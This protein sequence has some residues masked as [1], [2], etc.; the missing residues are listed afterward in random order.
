M[1]HFISIHENSTKQINHILDVAFKLREQRSAGKA[2]EPILAGKTLGV[3]FGKPSLRTRVSFEQAMNE[4]GGHA[5]ILGRNEVGIGE[6]ES[7]HDVIKVLNGMIHGLAAR[8]FEHKVLTQLA[9][10]A[11]IPIINALSDY[12][13][14]CQA[15]A[16]VMTIIDEFGR[17]DLNKRTVAYI[18]DGNNVALSLASICGKLGMRFVI[19]SPPGFEL[20][21]SFVDRIMAQQPDMDFELTADPMRAVHDADVLY[22]DTWVSMGQ[23]EEHEKR[24]LA[25]KG[26]QIT[27]AMVDDAPEHAIVLHCLPAHRGWEI[28]DEV[29]DGPRSRV[30]PEAHNRLHAQKGLLAV[31]MGGA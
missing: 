21:S 30:F 2:N 4:L 27:Q 28:T 10:H 18:G 14:P 16:D 26:Y 31:L 22:T 6:R 7:E 3:Y 17:E 12:S 29:M 1:T 9:E 24:K 8:V 13:H 5:I 25:F 15:L 19:A 20:D 23:E 11:T